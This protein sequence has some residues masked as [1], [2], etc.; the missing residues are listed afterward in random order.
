[1]KSLVTRMAVDAEVRSGSRV[2]NLGAKMLDQYQGTL[3]CVVSYN[4]GLFAECDIVDAVSTNPEA[5]IDDEFWLGPSRIQVH[6]D[7][8]NL[9]EEEFLAQYPVGRKFRMELTVRVMDE[10]IVP[11][12]SAHVGRV[13]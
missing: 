12:I 2:L 13:N 8:L 9:D 3:L 5:S 7:L 4:D 6:A 11:A 1:M 10:E